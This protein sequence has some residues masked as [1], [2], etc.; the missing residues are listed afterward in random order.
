NAA[1]PLAKLQDGFKKLKTFNERAIK[2]VELVGGEIEKWKGQIGA[3]S[4]AEK[5]R[6]RQAQKALA[7]ELK[8]FLKDLGTHGRDIDKG[9]AALDAGKRAEGWETLQKRTQE[10]GELLTELIVVQSRARVYLIKLRPINW[11]LEPALQYA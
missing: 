8:E 6:E 4:S 5:D 1:P 10:S 11:Q 2:L 3:E 9:A 7:E